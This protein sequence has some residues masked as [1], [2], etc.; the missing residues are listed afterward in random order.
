MDH[1]PVESNLNRILPEQTFVQNLSVERL[2]GSE[3]TTRA[4][5]NST[6]LIAQTNSYMSTEDFQTELADINAKSKDIE[7][8]IERFLLDK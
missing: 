7:E 4:A 6:E 8:M 5:T 2:S 3:I 1:A